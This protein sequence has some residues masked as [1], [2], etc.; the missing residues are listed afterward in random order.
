MELTFN[1]IDDAIQM[2][3][4]PVAKI[5]C[6]LNKQAKTEQVCKFSKE[7]KKFRPH[8]TNFSL[9]FHPCLSENLTLNTWNTSQRTLLFKYFHSFKIFKF[10]NIK[11][12]NYVTR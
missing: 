7:L 1:T 9:D 6:M 4:F 11:Q 2:K 10:Y 3:I 8:E 5:N 12:K